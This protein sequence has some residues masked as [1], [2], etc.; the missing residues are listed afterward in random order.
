MDCK[1]SI[2]KYR[3]INLINYMPE[4][5]SINVIKNKIRLEYET[6]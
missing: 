4:L 1:I 3:E 6:L 2:M 5:F